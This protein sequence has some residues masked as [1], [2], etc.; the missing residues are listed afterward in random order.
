M[1]FQ[2]YAIFPHLNVQQNV[3]FGL[4][5]RGVPPS[6]LNDRVAEGL[7]MVDLAGYETR[8]PRQLS[9]GQ[10]QRVV[11]AR[12]VVM[13]PRVLLMDEPL[14]NLDAKLRI[15]LRRDLK[16][17]QQTLGLTTVYVTHDQEEALSLS[18]R[19]AVMSSGKILQVGSPADI[20]ERPALLS[21]AE[22]I[23]EGTFLRAEADGQGNVR[24]KNGTTLAVSPQ[25]H[26]KAGLVWVGF[27][28]QDVVACDVD[29]PNALTGHV[30]DAIYLGSQVRLE[31]DCGL[32]RVVSAQFD[33]R[34][35]PVNAARGTRLSVSIARDRVMLF[36]G[37]QEEGEL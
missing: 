24:L 3:A 25:Q 26:D 17:L 15:R 32:D 7:R 2:N 29:A 12:A 36:P 31:I 21:V 37:T 20:F 35:L 16:Q 27:R 33:G 4:K 5:E 30:T 11:I 19:I 14:A 22:F 18:D 23:G 9:G 13:R 34:A 28:P 6:E 8:M 1:V 10:Q